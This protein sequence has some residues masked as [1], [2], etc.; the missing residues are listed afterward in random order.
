MKALLLCLLLFTSL[1]ASADEPPPAPS[2]DEMTRDIINAP[3]WNYHAYEAGEDCDL[4]ATLA[5]LDRLGNAEVRAIVAKLMAR[6]DAYDFENIR[7]K[8]FVINR[9]VFDIA[10][11]TSWRDAPRVIGAMGPPRGTDSAV[12]PLVFL[13]GGKRVRIS[14]RSAGYAGPELYQ[15]LEEFDA[16]SAKFPRR[17][18]SKLVISKNAIQPR[19]TDW[20]LG[21]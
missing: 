15:G 20:M 13:D 18:L 14:S 9:L 3:H 6:P 16:F 21:R 17:D 12:W 5:P 4:L 11:E 7:L 1:S 8:V 19:E 10:P 2:L